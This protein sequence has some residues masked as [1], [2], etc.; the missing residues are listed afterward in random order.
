MTSTTTA[1]DIWGATYPSSALSSASACS[2]S[3]SSNYPGCHLDGV[4]CCSCTCA[5]C[6][7]PFATTAAEC[8]SALRAGN[9]RAALFNSPPCELSLSRLSSPST[10]V[11]PATT[12]GTVTTAGLSPSNTSTASASR[13]THMR[14]GLLV[15]VLLSTMLAQGLMERLI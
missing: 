14:G 3:L 2:A 5:G 6:A 1:K 9:S 8:W 11:C 12:T 13:H 7:A 15:T 4:D 10:G